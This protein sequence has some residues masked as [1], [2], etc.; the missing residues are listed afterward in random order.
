M[1]YGIVGVLV[2]GLL[3]Y[4]YAAK[5]IAEYEAAAGAVGVAFKKVEGKLLAVKK[6][7]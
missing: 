2:G 4:L 1:V 7:L 3:S 5:V 6:V